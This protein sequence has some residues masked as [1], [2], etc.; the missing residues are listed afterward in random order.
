M[1]ISMTKLIANKP[2]ARLYIYTN[3]IANII[4]SSPVEERRQTAQKVPLNR[5]VASTTLIPS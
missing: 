1:K 2:L 3:G 4:S 5:S